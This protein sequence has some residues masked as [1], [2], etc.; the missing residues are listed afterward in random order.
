MLNDKKV[1]GAWVIH[2]TN[3]IQQVSYQPDF[4]VTA[5]SGKA[6]LL[7]SALSASDEE[8]TL[9]H[10]RVNALA[11]ATNINR[12]ELNSLLQILKDRDLIDSSK[13]DKEVVVLGVTSSSALEHTS[14]IFFSNNPR[15]IEQAALAL[16]EL[17]SERPYEKNEAI[18]TL[19][20]T[21][22]L[23]G[24]DKQQL[25]KSAEDIGFV[26]VERVDS[27]NTL[28]FN[29][30][31][32]RKDDTFKIK[33]ILDSLSQA[34]QSKIIELNSLLERSACIDNEL[35]KR[36]LGEQLY[37]KVMAV[38]L[39]DLN[40]VS[41]E[42]DESG[43]LTKPSAFSKYSTS[44]VDDAFDL[45]K[46]FISSLTFGM[47]K[48]S[49]ARGQITMVE[50]LLEKLVNG[51]VVGP[52][53]AIA[54]DYKILEYR[55]VVK[56]EEKEVSTRYGSKKGP[57]MRLLKRDVGVLALE[58]IKK[59]DVSEES[60]DNFPSA[61]ISK[62]KSPEINRQGIRKKQVID[63]PKATNDILMMLRR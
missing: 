26:D 54:H 53:P 4:E 40:I 48:S 33:R 11:A 14:D 27:Q 49:H 42:I 29:G 37:S 30:N 3:K 45:V 9:K 34:D 32:F 38:G 46:A 5:L 31:L 7:L 58:A 23:N 21:F 16:S 61:S 62:Y 59:C 51:G 52:A 60:L 8:S 6:G 50:R 12:L 1:S 24:D 13:S 56:V 15:P 20:D 25:F 47:T 2:H 63:N 36:V 57:C 43:F 35:A 55:N 19:G 41:N 22:H 44:N 28:L 18:E 39:Y 17:A 10:E